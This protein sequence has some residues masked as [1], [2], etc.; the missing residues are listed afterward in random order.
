MRHGM[1]E[2]IMKDQ[3]FDY[4]ELHE[5]VEAFKT[6]SDRARYAL[7]F[8]VIATILIGVSNN[9]I[10]SSS[11]PLR[12]LDT[13]YHYQ[14]EDPQDQSTNAL[15]ASIHKLPATTPQNNIPTTI[16][17]GNRKRLKIARDEYHRQFIDHALLTS[18]PIPGVWI[19]ANDLGLVGGMALLLLMSSLFFC[20]AREHENLYLA[21][22]RVR[23][24]CELEGYMDGDSPA[25][26]LYH[27]LA[28]RQ[29]LS[30]PPTLARWKNRGVLGHFGFIF[31][32]PAL[33][34]SWLV[35]TNF[36]TRDT[37]ASYGVNMTHLL[38]LQVLIAVFLLILGT[39][40][41]ALS[42]AMARRWRRAFNRVNPYREHAPQM[43]FREWLNLTS[44]RE[45]SL[46]NDRLM[47]TL[48]DTLQVNHSHEHQ[49]VAIGPVKIV[50]GTAAI[51]TTNRNKMVKLLFDEGEKKAR[52][53]C[54]REHK[55][56]ECL[57][58]FKPKQNQ[59]KDSEWTVEGIWDFC[60]KM[61]PASETAGARSN[62]QPQKPSELES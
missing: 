23:S 40:V 1:P 62:A 24:L 15:S 8:V 18:S 2:A 29:V 13:W 51:D 22:H 58:N 41:W 6:S 4:D 61:R 60:Y 46:A 38:S 27:A 32:L 48:V 49:T 21:L 12:R 31:F 20:V 3:R 10:Q 26:F 54:A 42:H 39:S 11:W 44:K 5:Y 52:E 55:L 28:M 30:F 34:Y 43:T 47:A 53:W 56:F 7:Y 9:N 59:W 57:N 14:L 36:R 19:D 35:W 17:R 16:A 45:S 37:G 25:N 50:P 33:V